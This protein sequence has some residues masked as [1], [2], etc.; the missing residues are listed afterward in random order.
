[1]DA[2]ETEVPAGIPTEALAV[3]AVDI[4]LS[5]VEVTFDLQHAKLSSDSGSSS[6]SVSD[7]KGVLVVAGIVVGR[8][9]KQY[10]ILRS[11]FLIL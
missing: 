7:S 6:G 9:E 3:V 2:V 10:F 5:I 4:V 1:M 8:V 11:V